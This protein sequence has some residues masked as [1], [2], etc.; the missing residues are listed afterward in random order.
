MDEE[1]LMQGE[2]TATWPPSPGDNI[3]RPSESWVDLHLVEQP[4]AERLRS[5]AA[6]IVGVPRGEV[7]LVVDYEVIGELDVH[8]ADVSVHLTILENSPEI[9]GH[10]DEDDVW[11]YVCAV[12]IVG[13]RRSRT[14]LELAQQ[15]VDLVGI[16]GLG[17]VGRDIEPVYAFDILKPGQ[18]PMRVDVD[19]QG[20]PTTLDDARAAGVRLGSPLPDSFGDGDFNFLQTRAGDHWARHQLNDDVVIDTANRIVVSLSSE[21]RFLVNGRNL[22]GQTIRAVERI[23]DDTSAPT[24]GLKDPDAG[25]WLEFRHY[26][27]GSLSVC[28]DYGIATDV[29][30]TESA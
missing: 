25:I 14:M 21:S 15:F 3:A 18:A 30:Y 28:F 24:G 13:P 23:L 22:I 20:A 4:E 2:E 8:D 5:I 29:L 11:G 26:W 19:P 6:A 9:Q 12:M 16:A 27:D 10:S 7:A 1:F 17:D